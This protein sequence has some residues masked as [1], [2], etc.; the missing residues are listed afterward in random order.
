MHNKKKLEIFQGHED[1]KET[2]I[3][4]CE[5][6]IYQALRREASEDQQSTVKGEELIQVHPAETEK[7]MID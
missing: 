4:D 6:P 3:D 5:S 7:E 2:Q 1:I